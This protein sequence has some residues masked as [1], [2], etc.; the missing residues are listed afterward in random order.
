MKISACMIA[1]DEEGYI[2]KAIGSVKGLADEVI[3][4][5]TGSTDNTVKIAE[6][7]GAKVLTGG[8]KMHKA[9]SRNRAINTATG[10]WIIS[11]DCD[12]QI[13]DIKNTKEEIINADKNGISGIYVTLAYMTNDIA[14]Y[15]FHQL[16][17]WKAGTHLY[18]YR[19]HEV[20]FKIEKEKNIKY[21]YSDVL[22]EHRP[23]KERDAWKFKYTLDRLKLDNKE[24]PNNPRILFYLGR[25][26]IYLE[27][28]KQAIT[29]FKKYFKTS[30]DRDIGNAHYFI[31]RAYAML[32]DTTKYLNH[33]YQAVSYEPLRREWWGEIAEYYYRNRKYTLAISLL[34][35]IGEIQKP[36]GTYVNH[37][38]YGTY[39]YDFTARCLWQLGRY[40]EGKE[41][42]EKAL[43]LDPNNQRLLNNLKF[44]IDK[45]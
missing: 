18:R 12:E 29:T 3:V 24:N 30:G 17:I 40:S 38:W 4:V 10:D 14:T 31:A 6:E 2:E 43:S 23:P 42:A 8:D 25:Q 11:L 33:L 13:S 45:L 9:E 27:K 36:K 37:Y 28:P 15:S 1:K 32:K 39:Y 34:K 41:Y 5:D 16:R 22:F 44:F 19:A 35:L 20:P 7:L 21:I 26:Y